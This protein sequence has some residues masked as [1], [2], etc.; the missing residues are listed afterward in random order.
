MI[1]KAMRD[2]VRDMEDSLQQ[3]TLGDGHSLAYPV[4]DAQS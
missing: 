3:D 2:A 4:E 1:G